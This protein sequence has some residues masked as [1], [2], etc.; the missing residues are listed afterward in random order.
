MTAFP[1]ELYEVREDMD[2]VELHRVLYRQSRVSA[3]RPIA[4]SY[5]LGDVPEFMYYNDQ[6]EPRP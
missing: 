1:T 2:V 4:E 5:R 3:N 6:Q